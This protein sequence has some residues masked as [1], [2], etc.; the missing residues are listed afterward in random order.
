MGFSTEPEEICI[1]QNK[2]KKK[3]KN[4]L[5]PNSIVFSSK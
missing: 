5:K 2:I 4:D 1:S 3:K